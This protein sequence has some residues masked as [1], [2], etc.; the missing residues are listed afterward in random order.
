M[1]SIRS[2][3]WRLIYYYFVNEIVNHLPS[4]D[5]RIFFLRLLG[6]KIGKKS[7]IDL[8]CYLR[9]ASKLEIGTYSHINRRC[10]INAFEGI[11][12]GNNV[13]ISFNVSILSG[14]H[15][16]NSPVFKCVGLPIIIDDYAWVGVNATIL[17]GCHIGEGAVIAAGA[18]V[19]K[20]V[21]P[22]TIVGGIPAKIIGHRPRGL[23]YRCLDLD[24]INR[25][26]FQ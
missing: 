21:P 26:R 24:G 22:Y 25:F 8:H 16:V 3:F 11:K 2:F 23:N 1:K 12:I 9:D 4:H 18:I 5:I 13:S 6:A 14:G 19:N 10:L 20:D 7:R 15:D 17:K